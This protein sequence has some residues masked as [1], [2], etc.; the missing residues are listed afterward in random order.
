MASVLLRQHG[1]LAPVKVAERIGELA[2]S[3]EMDGV[4]LWRQVAHQLDALI[5][6][7]HQA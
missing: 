3:S 4:A 6:Q 1:N 7:R 2:A 5:A